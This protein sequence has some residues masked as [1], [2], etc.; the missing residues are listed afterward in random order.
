MPQRHHPQTRFG[1]Y[2]AARP[3]SASAKVIQLGEN[4]DFTEKADLGGS[5][6]VFIRPIRFIRVLTQLRPP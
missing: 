1:S 2:S 4:A 3:I 6:S 5:E